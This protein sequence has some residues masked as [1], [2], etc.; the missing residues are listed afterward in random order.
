MNAMSNVE[1]ETS[2]GALTI[3]DLAERT[4][5]STGTLRMWETRYG[6][7]V[8]QRRAS[9]HR[10]YD[11]QVVDLALYGTHFHLGIDQSG[12]SNDLLDHDAPCALDLPVA[13]RRRDKDRL[14]H[15]LFELVEIKG[16]V[17][18]GRGQPE[19]VLDEHVFTGAVAPPPTPARRQACGRDDCRVRRPGGSAFRDHPRGCPIRTSLVRPL[20]PRSNSS[21]ETGCPSA[22]ASNRKIASLALPPSAVAVVRT[23]SSRPPACDGKRIASAEALGV[24]RSARRPSRSAS[25]RISIA[26]GIGIRRRAISACERTRRAARGP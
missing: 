1:R 13:R 4:G 21:A 18:I 24:A 22:S 8:P 19:S 9:G 14:P 20:P 6:F 15:L 10:R 12:R 25:A 16:S 26:E 2:S 11:E 17:V 7:P 23:R 5:V 3:G